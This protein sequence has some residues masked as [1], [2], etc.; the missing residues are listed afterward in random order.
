M[1]AHHQ[2]CEK[3]AKEFFIV[4]LHSILNC[5]IVML[6]YC[7]QFFIV[8]LIAQWDTNAVWTR[9]LGLG[10]GDRQLENELAIKRSMLQNIQDK[11][12]WCENPV[13]VVITTSSLVIVGFSFH[14]AYY[15]YRLAEQAKEL[16]VIEVL[17]GRLPVWGLQVP[18]VT[19]RGTS[20]PP[21]ETNCNGRSKEFGSTPCCS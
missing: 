5:V 18:F 21:P 6:W 17:N 19:T 8:L 20:G 7:I 13:Y 3:C 12:N 4:V 14:G 16:Y 11:D 10:F 9:I 1:Y 2:P 15:V